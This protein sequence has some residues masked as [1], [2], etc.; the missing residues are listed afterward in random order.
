MGRPP[1]PFATSIPYEEKNLKIVG[2]NPD[3]RGDAVEKVTGRARYAADYNLPGQLIGKVLRSPH[4][5]AR[6]ISI[7]TS[8]AEKLP[9]VKA[10]V[11]RDD[12]PDMEVEHAASGELI[13]EFAHTFPPDA[14]RLGGPTRSIAM[15]GDLI[16][17]ATYDAA[18]VA[19]PVVVVDRVLFFD[20]RVVGVGS[21]SCGVHRSLGCV[22]RVR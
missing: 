4:A 12:F 8:E 20:V 10:V 21:G 13:W 19:I 17:L 1:S 11:T 16:Y 9:G 18:I 3:Q 2:S 15:F 6:V 22:V 7:D 5:H 14:M